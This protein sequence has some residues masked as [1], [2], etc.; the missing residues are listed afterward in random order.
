MVWQ[1]S[2]INLKIYDVT[3][4]EKNNYNTHITHNLK[5]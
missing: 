5:K 3:N 4:W 2:D 1:V